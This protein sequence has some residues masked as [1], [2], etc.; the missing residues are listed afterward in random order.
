MQ[1]QR[2][3]TDGDLADDYIYSVAIPRAGMESRTVEDP[4]AMV[5]QFPNR[6]RLSATKVFSPVKPYA[7]AD[8]ASLEKKLIIWAAT[9]VPAA[10]PGK[11]PAANP[12]PAF[13]KE[14]L[15]S[16]AAPGTEVAQ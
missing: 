2:R 11:A 13:A 1:A 9:T 5:C 12:A 7:P 15:A 8:R 14:T 10:A 4:E 16:A 3:N 6:L